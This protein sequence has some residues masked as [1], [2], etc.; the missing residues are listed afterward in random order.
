MKKLEGYDYGIPFEFAKN[1]YEQEE[2]SWKRRYKT[3]LLNSQ[4]YQIWKMQLI[5]DIYIQVSYYCYI[6]LLFYRQHSVLITL[7]K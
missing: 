4:K 6:F 5:N 1:N 2:R 7:K 3:R